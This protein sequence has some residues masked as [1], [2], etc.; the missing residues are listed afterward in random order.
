MAAL[1]GEEAWRCRGC[2]GYVPLSQRLYRTTSEAWH[3]SCFRMP[4]S[5]N[6]ELFSLKLLAWVP[7]GAREEPEHTLAAEI[8]M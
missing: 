7:P 3:S 4:L 1:A 6:L 5:L 8:S 2:G